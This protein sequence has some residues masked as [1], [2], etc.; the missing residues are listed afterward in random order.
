MRIIVTGSRNL[1]PVQDARE[2]LCNLFLEYPHLWWKDIRIV[3]GCCPSNG[4]RNVDWAFNETAI[5][6][7]MEV[8]QWHP[9]PFGPWPEC[10]PKRN[11]AMVQAGAD[12]GI[13]YH[14]NLI[15]SKGTLGCVRLMLYAGIPVRLYGSAFK[16]GSR[17]VGFGANDTII[18]KD[19]TG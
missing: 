12:L 6:L 2:I 17:I 11:K 9:E 7:G 3:H 14:D 18:L 10:G 8:E 4:L 5:K 16:P 13:A 19:F 1:Y 15:A